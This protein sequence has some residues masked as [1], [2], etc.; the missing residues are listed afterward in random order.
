[1]SDLK[2]GDTRLLL[3][4]CQRYGLLR[5]QA[6]YVLATAYWET[7]QTMEPVRETLADNDASVTARLER[8]WKSGRL[9]WVSKPY[10]RSGYWGRGYVQLTHEE[11]YARAGRELGVD[12]VSDPGKA[13]E[14]NI[15]AEVLVRGMLEGW[16]TGKRLEDY[17]TLSAS[18][19]R[20]ARRV[21]NGKDKASL[22][23]E[24][25]REYEQAL[26]AEGYGLEAPA[27]VVNER[28]DGTAPRSSIAQ[29]TTVRA[30]LVAFMASL[31][32]VVDGAKRAIAQITDALGVSPEMALFLIAVAAL[33]WIFR[34]R[35]LKFAGG[36][37]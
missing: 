1:M 26:L 28:R 9:P 23:A 3:R 4:A 17:V 29:S 36:I 2:K 32:Q 34:E 12:L 35:L 31:G 25:A 20:G 21:V 13:L 24:L 8:A 6:A 30:T 11:N 22:I 14:S 7:A 15:A 18:N 10:W 33:S 37:R 27:P 5:N 16:F 19:Y